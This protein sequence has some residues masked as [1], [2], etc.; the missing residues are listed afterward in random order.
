MLMLISP[1]KTLD[2]E[3]TPT[4]VNYSIPEYLGQSSTL[5]DVVKKKSNREL[6][7]LMQVSQKIAE[8]N[9]ERFN[10]WHLPFN[11]E[12]AKQ[13]VF[14]FKGDV[15]TGLDAVALSENR[16][17]YAQSHLRIVSGLYGLLRPLD[18]MQ[19][20]RL[21]MGLKLKT[22]KGKTLYQFWGE[23]ITDSLN[24]L[25]EKQDDPVLVNLASNEYFKAIQKE[26]LDGRLITPE[27]K[28]WKNGKYKMISFFA[29]KARGMMVRYA[30]DHNIQ[31]AE[32]LQKFDYDGYSYNHELSHADKWVFCRD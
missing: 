29:K 8:L 7:K 16:L 32:K 18:L 13:A 20:Y 1:S 2:F 14:T 24:I 27:F 31:N 25:L 26:N 15:Y 4:T 9:V 30:I 19:P 22:K 28:D 23:Q 12:N 17:E 21:E 10:H 6:M 11:S 5:I 3:T